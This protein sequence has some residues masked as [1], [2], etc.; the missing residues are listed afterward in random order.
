M[1]PNQVKENLLGLMA[2]ITKEI[3]KITLFMIMVPTFGTTSV[4]ILENGKMGK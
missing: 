4:N 3:L 1:A 2:A